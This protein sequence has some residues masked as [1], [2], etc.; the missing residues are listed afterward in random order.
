[1]KSHFFFEKGF[2][3]KKNEAIT[4]QC[5]TK[6]NYPLTYTYDENHAQNYF[7]MFLK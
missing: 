5:L 6:T 7:K 4:F 2:F 1:M 3:S